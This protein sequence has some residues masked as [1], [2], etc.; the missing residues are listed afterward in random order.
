MVHAVKNE[1]RVIL[2]KAMKKLSFEAKKESTQVLKKLL[3]SAEKKT[4]QLLEAPK[5]A[6]KELKNTMYKALLDEIDSSIDSIVK[7]FQ[8]P[9]ENEGSVGL[10]G[11]KIRECKF[12]VQNSLSKDWSVKLSGR[13]SILDRFDTDAELVITAGSD[14]PNVALVLKFARDF[15]IN[16]LLPFLSGTPVGALSL[17]DVQ[18]V[19][20]TSST[21][22]FDLSPGLHFTGVIVVNRNNQVFNFIKEFISFEDRIKAK[23]SISGES[24]LSEIFSASSRDVALE[25]AVNKLELGSIVQCTSASVRLATYAPTFAIKAHCGIKIGGADGNWAVVLE[26]TKEGKLA[27][28]GT[29]ARPINKA[30]GI[31]GFTIDKASI[32]GVYSGGSVSELKV[33]GALLFGST[34]MELTGDISQAIYSVGIN[35]VSLGKAL[36]WFKFGHLAGS[37]PKISLKKVEFLLHFNHKGGPK[38][39]ISAETSGTIFDHKYTA[40]SML[41]ISKDKLEIATKLKETIKAGPLSVAE[42]SIKVIVRQNKPDREV[43]LSG[44]T[45]FWKI[46]NLH[47]DVG[48]ANVNG[49]TGFSL[50]IK[51]GE[52]F[53]L[54]QAIPVLKGTPFD[55]LEFQKPAVQI[56]SYP[57]AGIDGTLR[58]VLFY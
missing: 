34:T 33:K 1:S 44:T 42:P 3:F 32:G 2:S 52:S 30:L 35:N 39:R 11:V 48:V 38:L 57:I 23:L 50:V 6:I 37:V 28:S 47:V 31:D 12:N 46:K 43:S 45:S 36:E 51:L 40:I 13:V 4:L 24:S 27:I 15:N 7:K 9:C 19:I 20:V 10:M 41:D 16:S 26:K 56:S 22:D 58:K 18:L 25:F 54:S 17:E 21:N 8:R 14:K 29:L 5:K 55:V 49:Q 53:R